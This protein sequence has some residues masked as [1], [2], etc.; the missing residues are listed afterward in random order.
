ML[1]PV[2]ATAHLLLYVVVL[3]H[4]GNYFALGRYRAQSGA[5]GGHWPLEESVSSHMYV[6]VHACKSD[7]PSD[8]SVTPCLLKPAVWKAVITADGAEIH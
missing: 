1:P 2:T 7:I 3:G 8:S 4:A 6:G 5:L